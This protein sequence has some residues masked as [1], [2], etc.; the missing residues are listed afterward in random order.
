MIL[1]DKSKIGVVMSAILSKH[2]HQVS[3]FDS[4]RDAIEAFKEGGYALLITDLGLTDISGWEVINIARQIKPDVVAGVITG[5]D[6]S[7]EEAKQ[8]GADFLINKPF[9]ANQLV[10]EVANA[11]KH[12]AA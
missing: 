1:D 8:K 4:S 7:E 5:W 2:G 11:L 9:E 6:I 3:V 10:Q 12:S